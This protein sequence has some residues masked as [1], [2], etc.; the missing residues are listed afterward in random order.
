MIQVGDRVYWMR[1]PR[2]AGTERVPGR[3]LD[4]RGRRATITIVSAETLRL[5]RKRV[6]RRWL[7]PREEFVTELDAVGL[8]KL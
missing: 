5:V 2:G 1:R 4:D 3:V 8:S 7:T 6:E